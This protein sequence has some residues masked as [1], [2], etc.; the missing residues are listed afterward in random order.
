MLDLFFYESQGNKS[1]PQ[2]SEKFRSTSLMNIP[3]F[4]LEKELYMESNVEKNDVKISNLE[5]KLAL[6]DAT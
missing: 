5:K 1:A 2:V 3:L 6:S 4:Q